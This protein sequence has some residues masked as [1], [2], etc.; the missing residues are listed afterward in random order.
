M[1]NVQLAQIPIHFIDRDT[2]GFCLLNAC[3]LRRR[4]LPGGPGV[5]RGP[6][7]A[8]A[9]YWKAAVSCATDPANRDVVAVPESRPNV[10]DSAADST[11]WGLNTLLALVRSQ[12]VKL[13]R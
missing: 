4:K 8:L 5:I 11:R 7:Y 12:H 1:S 3:P 6:G 9:I 13:D 2:H 10:G